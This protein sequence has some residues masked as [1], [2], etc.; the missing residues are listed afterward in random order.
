MLAKEKWTAGDVPGARETLEEAFKANPE[1]EQIWLAAVKLEAE[2]G[3]LGVARELLTRARKVAD[4]ERVSFNTRHDTLLSALTKSGSSQ[5]WMKSAVFERQQGRLEEALTTVEAGL[6]KFP[7]FA[8][9][10]MLKGQILEDANDFAGARAAYAAGVKANPKNVPLWLLSSRLEER[11][12]RAIKA[13]ALLEKARLVNPKEDA[14]WA[15]AVSVEERAS[16]TAQA[17]TVLARGQR[18]LVARDL[19][20]SLILKRF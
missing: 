5:I 3:E 11:D 9:L 7:A 1:S 13:R 6:K 14:L 17:N 10:H 18:Y 20:V 12:G 15:E 16:A 19:G 4:T 8:K 2:N